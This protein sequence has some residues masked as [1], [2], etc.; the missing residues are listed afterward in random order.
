MSAPAANA[1]AYRYVA[2]IRG[3]ISMQDSLDAV[4]LTVEKIAQKLA[5]LIDAQTP[6]WNP[7]KEDW[8]YF[9]D[10]HL[11]L[12]AL[13]MIIK[14]RNLYPGERARQ[15]PVVVNVTINAAEL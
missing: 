11:Q 5:L 8:D 9:E 2:A 10:G 3:R 12:A 13:D 6:K 15:D 1:N 4:G 7:A 14:L